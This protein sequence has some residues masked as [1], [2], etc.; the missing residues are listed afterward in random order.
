MKVGLREAGM[1]RTGNL[2]ADVCSRENV[3]IAVAK[4]LKRKDGVLSKAKRDFISD[5]ERLTD[6]VH[7]SLID[8]TYKLGPLYSFVAYEPK[9]RVIFCPQFY[10]DR[11]LHHAVMNV[12]LPL[13]VSKFTADTYGSIKNRGPHIAAQKISKC[14][15]NNPDAY[16]LQV[17]MK[18]F[19][20]NID[21][22]IAK[23]QLRRVIK[24][25]KT[26]RLF[27]SII[28]VHDKGVPI[29]SYTSQ[30]IGNLMLSPIDHWAKEVARVKYYFRY[31]DDILFILPD[32][33]SAH[34]LFS[35]LQ[36]EV[37]KLKL[38]I[39]NNVRIAPVSA[40]VDVIG[41]VFYPTHTRLRKRIKQKF[42]R[43]VRKLIKNNVSD[44]YFK[45][46]TASHFGWCVH[47]DCR[48]LLRKT[49]STRI[50]LYESKMEIKRLADIKAAQNWFGL[51]RDARV[52][53]EALIGKEIIFYDYKLDRIRG[54]EKA[55]LK[56]AFPSD[57]HKEHYTITRSEVMKDRLGRDHSLMPF[58]ATIIKIKNYIAYE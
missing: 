5:R 1:K 21:H 28:D 50:N 46:K 14:V 22:D 44:E 20:E 19:Y 11:I 23:A 57:K 33:A 13:F 27:D 32:K 12:T 47:A 15:R 30:Y 49:L 34:K 39:K 25:K 52:S 17:D 42:Q 36:V 54:E 31:M 4:A 37:D 10:P 51:R 43:N 29:G 48:N 24:C 38:I 45:R 8:E 6:E 58:M 53:I 55:I 41:Y 7:Q 35:A 9:K 40:G 56:F 18:S 2:W 26:L 16:Y 3:E